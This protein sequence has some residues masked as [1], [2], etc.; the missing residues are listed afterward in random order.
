MTKNQRQKK[1]TS[2]A[3]NFDGYDDA[4]VRCQAHCP[5][6]HVQGYIR[7]HWMPPLGK[8]SPHIAPADAM[9]IDFWPENRVVALRNRFLKLAFK[10]HETNPLL[11]SSKQQAA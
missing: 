10:R 2:F 4:P 3:G 9:V 8:Y 7:S 11:S 1:C 6:Q 5:M